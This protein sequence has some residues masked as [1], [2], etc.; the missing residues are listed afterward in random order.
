MYVRY[1]RAG[2]VVVVT[3]RGE[4]IAELTP[5]NQSRREMTGLL[6]L[7]RKGELTLAQHRKRASSYPSLPRALRGRSAAE[8]LDA[9]RNG[10]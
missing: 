8:L 2:E 7:A 6:G 1:V 5:P 10:R 9:E 3:D 4:I